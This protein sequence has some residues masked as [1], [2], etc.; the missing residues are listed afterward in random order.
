MPS[1]RAD[2][3]PVVNLYKFEQERYG[4][5]VIRFIY[6]KND[7]EHKLGETP[8]PGGMVKV[9]RTVDRENHLSYEGADNTKYI[10][11]DQKV[12]LNLG[13][14][15]KVA[16]EP[17]IMDLKYENHT[18]NHNGNINGWDEVQQWRVAAKNHRDVAIRVEIKRNFRHQY[19]KLQ[20][21]GNFG[22]FE[23]DDM[24]TVKFTLY[25]PPHTKKV[26]TYTIRYYE[27]ERRQRRE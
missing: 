19:W 8:L 26:F 10:P 24:G 5:K 3:V 1:F 23:R 21:R 4:D 18:F 15:Q 20:R 16:V 14:A 22:R 27:G 17:K 7:K 11:V 25:L 12:E 9:Y 2:G 13:P 6:F